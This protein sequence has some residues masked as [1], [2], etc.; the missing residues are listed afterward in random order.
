MLVGLSVSICIVLS[1]KVPEE[2]GI[3][4]PWSH[5]MRQAQLMQLTL[6]LGYA[7][8]VRFE[9]DRPNTIQP[10]HNHRRVATNLYSRM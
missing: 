10:L 6:H 4:V 2:V 8:G 1:V 3:V 7:S 5:A 9:L